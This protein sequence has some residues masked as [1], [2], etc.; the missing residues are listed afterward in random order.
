MNEGNPFRYKELNNNKFHD[1]LRRKKYTRKNKSKCIC[2]A[3]EIKADQKLEKGRKGSIPKNRAGKTQSRISQDGFRR[4]SAGRPLEGGTA[5][6]NT[7]GTRPSRRNEGLVKR[8]KTEES[9][10]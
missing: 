4:I 6:R 7:G 8:E 2:G 1:R 9:I 10:I 5:P 3:N